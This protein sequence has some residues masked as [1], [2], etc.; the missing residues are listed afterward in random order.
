MTKVLFSSLEDKKLS[1]WYEGKSAFSNNSDWIIYTTKKANKKEHVRLVIEGGRV[2]EKTE[3]DVASLKT[4]TTYK[5][6]REEKKNIS[7]QSLLDPV[8]FQK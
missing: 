8:A 4:V 3:S 7:G 2:V 1:R 5:N 6:G